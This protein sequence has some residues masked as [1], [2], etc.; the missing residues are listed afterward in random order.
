[1][2]LIKNI[3]N[4]ISVEMKAMQKSVEY[5]SENEEDYLENRLK[6]DVSMKSLR[7]ENIKNRKIIESKSKSNPDLITVN[8]ERGTFKWWKSVSTE[9]NLASSENIFGRESTNSLNETKTVIL[10]T[11][12]NGI[13]KQE[14]STLLQNDKKNVIKEKAFGRK[15]VEF[16]DLDLLKDPV[17][18]NI[19]LG[20]S[21][22]AC[23]EINFALLTPFILKDMN[24]TTAEI[25]AIL[26]VIATADIVFR[27]VSPFIGDWCKKSARIMYLTSLLMLIFTRSSK[28]KKIRKKDLFVHYIFQNDSPLSFARSYEFI[29]V[30]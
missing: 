6:D 19:V 9:I 4:V 12:P 30:G 28:Y 15:I 14:T 29:S 18:V 21:L 25:A 13:L 2:N 8:D 17:F 1:M 27:F 11:Q 26:S 22:A 24:F 7:E 5:L 3:E 10:N 23:A 16:F 20:I